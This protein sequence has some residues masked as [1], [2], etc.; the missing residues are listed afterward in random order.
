MGISV[1]QSVQRALGGMQ[2]AMK[3]MKAGLKSSRDPGDLAS[4]SDL[5][6]WVRLRGTTDLVVHHLVGIETMVRR[7]QRGRVEWADPAGRVMRDTASATSTRF[8]RSP[9]RVAGPSHLTEMWACRCLRTWT[10]AIGRLGKRPA[11]IQDKC[12]AY[13]CPQG[14]RLYPCGM[15]YLRQYQRRSLHDGVGSRR[16]GSKTSSRVR[17][18]LHRAATH[19]L[20]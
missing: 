9:K 18:T 2:V 16:L 5:D 7:S 6:T 20:V 17:G 13:T 11:M 19:S 12:T 10:I 1:E 15:R 3:R 8:Y 4:G 14:I